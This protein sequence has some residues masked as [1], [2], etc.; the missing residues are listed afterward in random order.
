MQVVII[1]AGLAGLSAAWTLAEAGHRVTVL[2]KADHVG[3]MAS[4]WRVGPFTLDHGP[5]RFHTRDQEL[6][7]HVYHILDNQVVI[8][9]RRSRI[10]L[11]GKYFDYPL[12]AMNV[13]KGLDVWLLGRA[14]AD[15]AWIR[16]KRRVKPIPDS[17][18]ENWVIQRFG[19]TLYR[20]FF[21]TYTA[22][23]WRMPC[24]EISADWA[25]QRIAQANLW[26]TIK[27]TLN[28]P[29]EGEV[30]S[31][32]TQF[33]YPA[34]GGIGALSEGYAN[35]LRRLGGEIVLGAKLTQLEIAAGRVAKVVYEHEG[36]EHVLAPDHVVN[37]APL[38]RIL[39][40]FTPSVP[41]SVRAAIANLKYI[42]I[43]FVYLE[44]A[45]PSV[46]P[47]HWVYLPSNELTIHRI[48]EFKNFSDSAAPGDRT[49][50]CCEIT[51]RPG[52]ERWQLGLAEAARIAEADLVSIGLL[53]PGEARGLD[54]AKLE[55]AYPV[56]DLGYKQNLM[57]LKPAYKELTNFHTTGRQGLYRYNNMDHSIAMGRKVARTVQ[58]GVD[59]GAAAVAEEQEY[60][61]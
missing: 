53:A 49:V 35:K 7:A 13:L 38:P 22:K 45:K 3:G 58:K 50:I 32:V 5:H 16:V 2:E 18:F 31:L 52:D 1:G 46:V 60:F 4:S 19:K 14:L 59:H 56:Y 21:G 42:G 28:P 37:T 17:N 15:Y 51:C 54:L 33:W 26:D 6:L 9:E 10:Y 55:Y 47:D 39:E 36:R 34:N 41:E 27:K 23:A 25:A 44:V 24:T 40:L 43:V 12:R 29:R 30:R 61:G 48:S 20:L 8:R 57:A 11:E